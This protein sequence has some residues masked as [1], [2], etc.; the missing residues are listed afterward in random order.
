MVKVSLNMVAIMY[1]KNADIQTGSKNFVSFLVVRDSNIMMYN[2][3]ICYFRLRVRK[4]PKLS[5]F[6]LYFPFWA[7]STP[8]HIAFFFLTRDVIQFC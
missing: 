4:D 2:K 6:V 1:S 8:V 7:G 5:Y 3:L